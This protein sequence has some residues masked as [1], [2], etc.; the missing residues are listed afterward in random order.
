MNELDLK[1]IITILLERI[2]VLEHV[3]LEKQNNRVYVQDNYIK[4]ILKDIKEVNNVNK[5]NRR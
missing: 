2:Q 3:L 4:Q 5:N 1:Q